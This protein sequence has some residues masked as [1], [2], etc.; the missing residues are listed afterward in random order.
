MSF[1][2]RLQHG[3]NA[4][5]NKDP[6]YEYRDYGPGYTYRPDRP[7]MT[8]GNERSIVTA[9]YNRIAL[10]V[11]TINIKHCKLDENGR[12]LSDID[13]TL[14]NCL[15][16]EANLDQTGRAFIQDAVMSMLDEGV[17]ALVPIDTS[18]DPMN[19]TSFD[20]LSIRTAKI[21]EWYP[22]HVKLLV[23]NDQTGN[24]EEIIMPKNKV[25]IVENPLYAVINEPNS[26]M[27]RLIRKL[28]LLDIV[29]EQS[30]AGKLDLIIQLPYTI[31]TEARRNQAEIRRK[32][33][34]MQL[35]GSKYGIAYTDG[36]ERITQL[37]RP[38]ENNLLKQIEYLTNML[39]S[40]IGFHQTI[41]DGTADEKTMLNYNNR[42]IEPIISTLVDEMKRKFLTKTART[43]RQSIMFFS[44]PFKLVP[45]NDI[46][47]I[48]DKFTRNEILT[49]NEIRQIIGRAP[50]SDPK[51]DTLRNSNLNHPDESMLGGTNGTVTKDQ[52][53]DPIVESTAED[54]LTYEEY[55]EQIGELDALDDEIDSLVDEL[56]DS[57]SL[58]HYASPYYDPVKDHEYY[59]R[60][61]EL[62][63]RK[64][65]TK[66]NDEGK[67][68]AKYIKEQLDA[69]K[70]EKIN[71]HKSSTDTQINAKKEATDAQIKS[72]QE[73]MQSE[74][75]SRKEQISAQ[76]ESHKNQTSN[77]IESLREKLKNM[78]MEDWNKH[79]DSIVNEIANLKESNS[80]IR[81]QLN[82]EY[83]EYSEKLKNEVSAEKSGLREDYNTTKSK[84]NT[85]HAAEKTRLNDEYEEK[86]MDEL[87]K[88]KSDSKFKKVAKRKTKSSGSTTSTSKS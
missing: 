11:A 50:S 14:N 61:R 54:D 7:R 68:A 45:I 84:L 81:E 30:S 83:S 18:I 79:A 17:V 75:K 46:S 82:S 60:T 3:F 8:R 62:K 34:E 9:I 6:T 2:E 4:F 76:V 74:L 22:A 55:K 67:N 77:K 66:L 16:L 63:E 40:Q 20:I 33:I 43:Q 41:L 31:K 26:T 71:A 25:G 44:D 78:S 48:A 88:L 51:A 23:Y 52:V 35:S 32:D 28:S 10:D 15:N 72:K 38:L 87:D 56:P 86:Y 12:Y 1:L 58:K 13:S 57:S 36:T 47:E 39:Y 85:D 53:T 49:S 59:M 21:V 37:N 5:M 19:T 70:K 42:I 65:T 80:S 24:K 29:D 27:Q 69:E 64:S 73:S